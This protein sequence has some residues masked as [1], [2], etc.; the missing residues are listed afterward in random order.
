MSLYPAGG[1]DA[2]CF[3]DGRVDERSEDKDHP[4]G[5]YVGEREIYA[6]MSWLTFKQRTRMSGGE[7]LTERHREISWTDGRHDE[8]LLPVT[9]VS[10]YRKL[11]ESFAGS[12]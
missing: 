4:K 12:G 7:P 2:L 5:G 8:E 9:I 10:F 3:A 11:D 1:G 6:H